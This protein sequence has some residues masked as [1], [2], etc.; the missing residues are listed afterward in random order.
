MLKSEAGAKAED[1]LVA[2][3]FSSGDVDSKGGE[4]AG[5]DRHEAAGGKY[6]WHVV[7]NLGRADA[8]E[9]GTED[10][11]KDQGEVVDAGVDGVDAVD[12]LEPDGEVVDEKEEGGADAEGEEGT[13]GDAALAGNA[14][15][16]WGSGLALYFM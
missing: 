4:E 16:H 3:P 12:G 7:P 1:D 2:D 14:W 9:D 11:G 5:T 10:L 6:E 15:R 8:G 13:E